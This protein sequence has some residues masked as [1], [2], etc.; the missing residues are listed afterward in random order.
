MTEVQ[1]TRGK[2][3]HWAEKANYSKETK[4]KQAK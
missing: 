2:V 1:Q 3:L 4:K